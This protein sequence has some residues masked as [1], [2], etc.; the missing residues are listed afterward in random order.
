MQPIIGYHLD[1]HDDWVARLACGHFQ[2]VRHDPPLVRRPWTQ[3]EQGRQSMIGHSLPCKK[4][5]EGAPADD[6]EIEPFHCDLN[7]SVPDWLIEYPETTPIFDQRQIDSS[8]PGKSL[9]YLCHQ[10]GLQPPI[11]LQQLYAAIVQSRR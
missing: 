10:M 2:H 1:E 9:E 11:V 6:G 8:C 5:D 7:S 3:T 4:C